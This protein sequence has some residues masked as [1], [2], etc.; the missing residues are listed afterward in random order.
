MNKIVAPSARCHRRQGMIL[1]ALCTS[2]LVAVVQAAVPPEERG[3]EPQTVL[4][5]RSAPPR[6]TVIRAA[7]P[8]AESS[9]TSVKLSIK[10]FRFDGVS[11]VSADA[12]D[13][14]LAPWKGRELRFPEFELAVHA[15]ANYLR[16]HG[17]P[18]AEVK[19]SRALI[20][21]GTVMVAIQGLSSEPTALAMRPSGE[22]SIPRIEV[23]EFKVSGATLASKEEFDA[24][25]AS[26]SGKALSMKEI[27]QAAE[28]VANHL[29]SKGYPL[30]QA[31]LP[32]QRIDEGVVEIAVQEG[33]VDGSA[34][35]NG[36]IVA[37]GG[38]RVKQEV[39]EEI[40]AKGVKAGEPLRI[41]DLE[42]A[43]LLA[44][45]TPGIQSVK[46][47]LVPGS[48]PGS[49]QVEAKVEESALVSG[50]VWADNYGSRYT[51]ANR[52]NAQ[53]NLNSPSGHGEQISVNAAHSTG[54][55]SGKVAVQ[56]P[57]GADGLKVGASY[58]QMKLDIGEEVAPLN[59]SSNTTVASAYA[60]YPLERSSSRNTWIS[61][62][63][64]A[65]HVSNDLSGV[66]NNDR[67]INL[68]TL[69][70]SGNL[71]DP[72]EGQVSWGANVAGGA[73]DLSGKASYQALDASSSRT[74]GDFA[75]VNWNLQRT[76]KL[77][78]AVS[79]QVAA[80][81]MVAS[82]NLDSSEKFQLGG[83]TGVRA[84]PVGEG[85][86]DSGWL[87][88]AEVRYSLGQ[89]PVG[90]PQIF[91]FYDHGQI[92]QY[93][94]LWNH[95]LSAGQPNSYSLS[96]WGVGASLLHNDKES[97]RLMWA[98]KSGNNPNPSST[99]SDSDGSNKSGRL[100]IVG[101]ILF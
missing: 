97:L 95:A 98:Q 23:K 50:T 15:V 81:G 18:Q 64:D 75:K 28:S 84:Y 41:A 65:K 92:T 88:S 21:G 99:G 51:G 74:E 68:L 14:V 34:G 71:V 24:L 91:T 30:V 2:T 19:L 33:V 32:P 55:E 67:K 44:N 82:K 20:G 63:L 10:E 38:E 5:H 40:L 93:H 1:T 83:P 53:L 56:V 69:G 80:S 89:T 60:S 72:L 77:T 36:M 8:K 13:E 90:E 100:W 12:I 59:L 9:L 62:N 78:D 52:V 3:S 6:K 39:L 87:G 37:G 16:Q 45:D 79:W 101:N 47:T 43:V 57:V 66:R 26:S 76:A 85:L 73:L 61:A 94:T 4:D 86:G 46:T 58:S 25:L 42:R 54:M 22:E 11:E 96:G 31:F 49:T 7:M 48:A 29:R 17:H 70:A 27:E 35:N